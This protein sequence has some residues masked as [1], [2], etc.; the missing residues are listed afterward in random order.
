MIGRITLVCAMLCA[1]TTY[2]QDTTW[3]QTFTFDSITTR[4][5]DFQFPASLNTMRF[6]KVLM[7][8]KLKCSPL[9]TWDQYNCGEWDYLTYTRVFDHTGEYDST[10]VDSVQYLHD[11]QSFPSYVYDP[12]TGNRTDEY[13]VVQNSAVGSPTSMS[14]LS[15]SGTGDNYPFLL[16]ADGSHYQMLITA[17]ELTNGGVTPGDIQSLSLF[18]TGITGNGELWHPRIS[19]KGTTDNTLASLHRSG[20][21]EVYNFSWAS[22]VSSELQV[23]QNNFIFYQPYAWNG[24]DNIIIEFA[25]ESGDGLQGNMI[26]FENEQTPGN[27]AAKYDGRNGV[28]EFD[29]TNHGLLELS[30]INLD[31]VTIMFWAKGMG[32]TGVNTSILEAYDT[33][34]NR[35]IN[36]HMPWSN[37]RIYWDAGTGS[38]YDRI[39]QAMIPTDIDNEWHHWTFVKDQS[40]GTMKIFRDGVLWHSGTG[41]TRPVGYMHRLIL[42]AN[43]G[44]GNHWRGRIDEFQM[45]STPLSDATI[46]NWY[47]QKTTASHPDWADLRV[48]YDF[49]NA[50]VATDLSGNDHLLMPT[51]TG[52]I[53]FTERP[54]ISTNYASRKRVSLG[55]GAAATVSVVEVPFRVTKEPEVVFE[56]AAVDRHFEIVNA[57]L[58]TPSGSENTYDV[59]GTLTGSAPFTGAS[60]LTNTQ[61]TYYEQ[62]VELV[63]DVE[64]GRYITPYGIGFDLGSNGFTWIYDVTDYQ[65]YLKDVV[66][67]AAHNT[68]ELIDLKFAFIEGIP[69]RDVHDRRPVWSEWRSYG[70]Q[71]MDNDTELAS[72]NVVLADTSSM[73]KL[74]TRMS[75][76]GQ[77]GNQ[78]C[79]EWVQKDHKILVDGVERFNW[80]IWRTTACGDSPLPEQ[81]G[82]WPYAREGWCPGDLV[83][84][85]D[86]ELTPYVAPGATVALDY[87]ITPVPSADPGQAGGNYIA[88]FDL[89]SYSAPNFQR[90]AA[91]VDVLNPNSYEYYQKFNP[92]CQNPRVIIQNTG[93]TNMTSCKIRT[94]ISYGDFIDY[95]WAGDLAF[96]EKETVEIPVSNFSWWQ[97]YNGTQT[98]SAQVYDVNGMGDDEYSNN[99]LKEV[100]FN[101]PEAING[102]FLVWFTTNN[103][104]NENDW[105][106]F[107]SDGNVI[108]EQTTFSATTQYKDTFDLAP[109]CYSVIITDNDSDGLGYW[110]SNQVE[111]ET[112]GAFRLKQVGGQMIE[113][114]PTDFGNYHRF[115]FSVGF[116]VGLEEEEKEWP[117]F[118]AV[119]PNPNVG[120]FDVELNG[121]VNHKA[122]LTIFDMS[123]RVV[124]NESMAANA[125]SASA[126]VELGNVQPGMYIVRVTTA[127]KVYTT[128]FIKQ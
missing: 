25:F 64:I 40:A 68:Q 46:T 6:E 118:F 44:Q 124:W 113:I 111:G 67:L 5:A 126:H 43:S 77:V 8:Y 119:I 82:T 120:S 62:P 50:Q 123:G 127:E 70:Y 100:K 63:H 106:M 28:M 51:Q 33:V 94:W 14:V 115:D 109:G 11:F 49:D 66:D 97:D 88:A 35:I 45:F 102:P 105:Q 99:N 36:I 21:T 86:H 47:D 92:T 20:F 34:G 110:Y 72:T 83:P 38:G 23:G 42:G 22:L 57:F 17:S 65:M 79:C 85:F 59:N 13:T 117:E 10:R 81:G 78:A 41:L 112:N 54:L 58:A 1:L 75:G 87:D 19:I 60:T 107:D 7:Y 30:D 55:Q 84:E 9:T 91:L 74:K 128:E 103:K 114:F 73:F 37:N 95:Q 29:G 52:M 93:A 2:A 98:F 32:N 101:A 39:D 61:I 104:P 56:F 31:D 24:T 96:L 125:Q 18:V 116:S 122:D 15:G 26:S 121:A 48:Y 69:P 16:S 108:F 27:L 53:N 12:F 76:H 89:I 3:V 80:N 4:R 71:S 90:D